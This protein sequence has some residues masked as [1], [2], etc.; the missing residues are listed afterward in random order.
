MSLLAQR[1][2]FNV[3]SFS[4]GDW[5]HTH[6]DLPKLPV[7]KTLDELQRFPWDLPHI[8]GFDRQVGQ[9]RHPF[10]A[11]NHQATAETSSS[12]YRGPAA[13]YRETC[14]ELAE[15]P[16]GEGK[17]SKQHKQSKH[18]SWKSRP[19]LPLPGWHPGCF[20]VSESK[21]LPAHI[22]LNTN[23][24]LQGMYLQ[25]PVR[26]RCWHSPNALREIPLISHIRTSPV[27]I[28][29]ETRSVITVV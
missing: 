5:I 22:Y 1:G 12:V 27:V 11:G 7:P 21:V 18:E 9:A 8:F 10:V 17:A 4:G 3:A 14:K 6:P 20:Q 25:E 16:A 13:M 2:P 23:K 19:L 28:K 15:P 29:S 24:M 26:Q